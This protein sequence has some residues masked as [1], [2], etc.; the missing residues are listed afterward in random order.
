[1]PR[2]LSFVCQLL[3]AALLLPEMAMAR[4]CIG[5]IPASTSAFWTDLWTP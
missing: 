3:T 5:L 1:M 2:V 4:D